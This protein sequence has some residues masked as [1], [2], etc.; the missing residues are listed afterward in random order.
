MPG[1]RSNVLDITEIDARQVGMAFPTP[2]AGAVAATDYLLLE[3]GD[4]LL[5]E[6]GS[7]KLYLET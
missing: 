3:T 7:S 4:Y 1:I 6:D 2:V 5:L